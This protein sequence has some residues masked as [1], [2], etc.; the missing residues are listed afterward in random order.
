[1]RDS[2]RGGHQSGME[3]DP[4]RD[5]GIGP[6]GGASGRAGRGEK[7][8]NAS[9][10]R[11]QAQHGTYAEEL[12]DLDMQLPLPKY[13]NIH[14][15]GFHKGETGS[16]QDSWKLRLERK[17]PSSGYGEYNITFTEHGY[18]RDQ[19]SIEAFPEINPVGS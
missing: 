10:E 4:G 9:Q 12:E 16:F 15:H 7:R 6:P 8:A 3:Y 11:Y 18:D 2:R 1:M 19:S 17:G 14:R 13:F 5:A